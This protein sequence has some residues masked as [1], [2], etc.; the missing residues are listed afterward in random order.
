MGLPGK[1]S[2]L[3]HDILAETKKSKGSHGM[4]MSRRTFQERKTANAK[5]LRQEYGCYTRGKAKRAV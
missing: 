3:A 5:A 2:L 1:A 4:W